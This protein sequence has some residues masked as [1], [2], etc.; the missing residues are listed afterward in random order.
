MNQL[1][2]GAMNQLNQEGS[3]MKAQGEGVKTSNSQQGTGQRVTVA[4]R[5]TAGLIPKV[6]K[7]LQALITLTGFSQTDVVNRA[8]SIYHLITQSAQ[9]GYEFVLR[10]KETGRER[11]VE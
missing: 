5:I 11:V 10:H 9:E 4:G 6:W 8:I 3:G 7:E 2:H 1:N